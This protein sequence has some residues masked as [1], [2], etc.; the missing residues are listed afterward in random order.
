MIDIINES[1]IEE[2]FGSNQAYAGGYSIW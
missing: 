2:K 1:S